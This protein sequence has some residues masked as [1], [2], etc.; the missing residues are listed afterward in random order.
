[1]FAFAQLKRALVALF[2][3]RPSKRC[4]RAATSAAGLNCTDLQVA[5]SM[6]AAW[7]QGARAEH[8]PEAAGRWRT[9]AQ[10]T[11]RQGRALPESR[12]EGHH[13]MGECAPALR[14]ALP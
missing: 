1:M 9:G 11:G 3:L 10:A 13:A 4:E 6:S 12:P 8:K 14:R 2:L 5:V 7:R